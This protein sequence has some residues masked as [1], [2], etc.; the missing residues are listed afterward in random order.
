EASVEEAIDVAMAP[1]RCNTGATPDG[2]YLRLQEQVIG[3]DS[4]IYRHGDRIRDTLTATERVRDRLLPAIHAADWH[5]LVKCH[6]TT[7]TCFTTELMYRAALLRD[8]SR[9]WHYREDFPDRDDERWRVWLV[10][11]PHGNSSPPALWAAPEFRRLP[12][13]LDAY[14][15]RG[16]APT[17]AMALP[18]AAN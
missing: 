16:I 18:A 5:E 7:A 13:P 11:A 2:I 8:E 3:A 1:L 15:A 12:V 9:G 17:P 14:E 4:N 10:A 6:E